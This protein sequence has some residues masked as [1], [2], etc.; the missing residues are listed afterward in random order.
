MPIVLRSPDVDATV[1]IGTALAP[2]LRPHD[3]VLLSG[4]LGAGKTTLT[5]GVAQGLGAEEHVQSPTFVLVREYL[6]GR[7]PVAHVDVYRLRRLQDVMDLALEEL[8]GGSE[9]VVLV[10]WGD[11]VEDL[12]PGEHLRVTL[13]APDPMVQDRCIA[14]EGDGASWA[15]RW[16]DLEAAL[17]AW[18]DGAACT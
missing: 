15:S 7:L 6:T 4:D 16:G 1:A 11:T 10:E 12:W 18:K 2:L 13:T 3:V 17:A 5:R 8:E 9:G 14:F